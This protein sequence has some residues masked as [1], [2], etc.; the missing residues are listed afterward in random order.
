MIQHRP[1]ATAPARMAAAVLCSWAIS[2]HRS[3]G[4]SLTIM[5]NA[6]ANTSTPRQAKIRPLTMGRSV[7][8]V[9][10][11]T[12]IVRRVASLGRIVGSRGWPS[13]RASAFQADLHGFE[14]RTPLH[15]LKAHELDSIPARRKPRGAD[16][17]GDFPVGP[18]AHL[19]S[20]SR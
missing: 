12:W 1:S 10:Y 9:F 7:I 17:L 3:N 13:G 11:C 16:H 5:E 18:A 8:G 15:P 2:F 14:S 6:T 19:H 20:H 4:A